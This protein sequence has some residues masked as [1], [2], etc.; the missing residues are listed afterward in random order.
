MRTSVHVEE[1][2]LGEQQF[3]TLLNSDAI[4]MALTKVGSLSSKLLDFVQTNET[5]LI[6]IRWLST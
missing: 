2:K 6:K 5:D 4:P 3:F 1:T